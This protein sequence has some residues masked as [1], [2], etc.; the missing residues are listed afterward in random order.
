[1]DGGSTD[2][3]RQILA[4]AGEPSAGRASRTEDRPTLSTRR[5]R[6][7][8]A[9]SSA[10]STATTGSS[11]STPS[12]RWSQHSR[13]P[14]GRA[15]STAM[16]RSSTRAGGSS[17]TIARAGLPAR[18]RSSRRSS[19]RRHSS[20]ALLS[21][22]ARPCCGSTCTGSSTTSSGFACAAAA[23][24]FV[25]LPAVVAVDRDHP[26][27]KVRTTDEVFVRE[28]TQLVEEYGPVF[29]APRLRRVGRPA[30]RDPR[31]A[32]RSGAGS[33]TSRR[34]R[35]VSTDGLPAPRAAGCEARPGSAHRRAAAV[36]SRGRRRQEA[37]LLIACSVSLLPIP[38]AT[39]LNAAERAQRQVA[40]AR[41]G[42]DASG[43][44]RLVAVDHRVA[45][46]FHDL[47][48]RR[49]DFCGQRL[50]DPPGR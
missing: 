30:W 6:R 20:A 34:S 44:S 15:S 14:G 7:A 32:R 42:E 47:E 2:E 12:S 40:Q 31:A 4:G 46:A 1:M 9:R 29:G 35:G 11:R 24:V 3:S 23:C 26:Q 8:R 28:S 48:A 18:F 36:R 45:L 22:R 50:R 43:S 39:A 21:S 5:S 49:R 13:R 33:G 16:R 25:H 17:A 41:L 37:S 27:R 38:P 10:G 19:S